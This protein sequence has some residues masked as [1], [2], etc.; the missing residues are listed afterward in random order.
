MVNYSPFSCNETWDLLYLSFQSYFR[1]P[2]LIVSVELS[3][4]FCFLTYQFLVEL[5]LF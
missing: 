5:N 3:K 2:N 4:N 1:T